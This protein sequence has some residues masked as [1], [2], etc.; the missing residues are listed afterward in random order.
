MV[1]S[2]GGRPSGEKTRCS[3]RW[4]EAQYRSF[5]KGNLR[6]VCG[7][8]APIQ[9]AKKEA[10]TGRNQYECAC[11]KEIVGSSVVV[12]GK[13]VNNIFV[14]HIKPIVDPTVGWTT[15]DDCIESMFCEK[16]NLQLV[17]LPCHSVKS[18]EERSIAV[19]RRRLEKEV[20]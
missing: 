18:A 17:C 19:E 20:K 15:W 16:D 11:C 1:V 9:E 3:G 12:D 4:S 6:R 5:I 14:D 10:R 13:R 2:K 7:K 8:W